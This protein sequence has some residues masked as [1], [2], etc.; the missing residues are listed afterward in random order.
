MGIRFHKAGILTTIQDD[1]R[2]EHL[3]LGVPISGPM[4]DLSA[5][6]ANISLGNH[7]HGPI[8]EFTQANIL[9]ETLDNVLLAFSGAGSV[10]AGGL[11]IPK[12]TPVFVPAGIRVT[13]EDNGEGCRSYLAIAGGW[14]VPIVMGS[15]STCLVAG[16]GG[17]Q[18]RPLKAGDVISASSSLTTLT[19][20][21]IKKLQGNQVRFPTWS[22]AKH[23]LLPSIDEVTVRLVKGREQDWFTAAS[24]KRLLNGAYAYSK[25][26]NRIGQVLEGPVMERKFPKELI[27][28]AVTAG[29]IQVTNDGSLILLMS[30]CQTTGRYPRVAQVVAVDLA[31]CAQIR[32][33]HTISFKEVSA[34]EAEKLYI[35]REKELTKIQLAIHELYRSEL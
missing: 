8:L 13:I 4:D 21:I 18:G 1:G 30:D 2:W 34:F 17:F 5:R 27:S 31:I 9:F 33:G 35:Y 15:R 24:W 19:K 11:S 3:H 23:L 22:V 12:N 28:T 32:T 16:F 25:I 7:S 6:V 26:G 20:A 14:D 29:T 10:Q